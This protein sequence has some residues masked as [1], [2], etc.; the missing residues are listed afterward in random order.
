MEE[1]SVCGW[2]IS[3]L[4]IRAGSGIVS[5]WG[6]ELERRSCPR[7]YTEGERSQHFIW[8]KELATTIIIG[9]YNF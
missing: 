8:G 9:H 4:G 7:S 3:E 2:G 5:Q 1:I 6:K